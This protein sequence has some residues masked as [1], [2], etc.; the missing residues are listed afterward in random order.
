MI[1]QG[2]AAYANA[3]KFDDAVVKVLRNL[4]VR[5]LASV[6]VKPPDLSTIEEVKNHSKHSG[7]TIEDSLLFWAA[8]YQTELRN[9]LK[10]LCDD[11]VYG[12][13][14]PGALRTLQTH[15]RGLAL[16]IQDA[17]YHIEENGNEGYSVWLWRA[18]DRCET[19]L[20][21][22]CQFL[23][24]CIF[25]FQEG[26]SYRKAI[27]IRICDRPGCGRFK[28]PE[29]QR[30]RCYCSDRCRSAEFQSNRPVEKKR[31]YMREYRRVLTKMSGVNVSRRR[32]GTRKKR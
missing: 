16:S 4:I 8:K 32:T 3:P 31:K 23:V 29:R 9:L 15:S 14:G 12:R 24:D 27:P 22:I 10:W 28:L 21:P 1:W 18:L 13:L 6:W 30:A 11:D 26:L 7:I 5:C 25:S 19:L 17:N 20:S 2:I